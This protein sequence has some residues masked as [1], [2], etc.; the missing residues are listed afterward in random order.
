[1]YVAVNEKRK[2]SRKMQ[3]EVLRGKSTRKIY[4]TARALAE[5]EA[6]AK[7]VS[8]IKERLAVHWN[9][10]YLDLTQAHF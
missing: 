4:S 5:T 10:N 8:N 3:N 2:Q 6:I 7:D 9:D 1:M